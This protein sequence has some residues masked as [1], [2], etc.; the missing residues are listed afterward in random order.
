MTFGWLLVFCC[1]KKC[2]NEYPSLCILLFMFLPVCPWDGFLE[3]GSPGPSLNEK[4]C[5]CINQIFFL[6]RPTARSIFYI[7]T[8]DIHI[9]NITK[10]ALT[11]TLLSTIY[12]I[13]KIQL[14]MQ[15]DLLMDH[16][17]KF[18]RY[19]LDWGSAHFFQTGQIVFQACGLF[20]DW[21]LPLP[22]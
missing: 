3:E 12:F 18:K 16:D 21:T 20:V 14:T 6:P 22:L 4:Q 5:S 2:C 9:G 7:M 1:Y 13:F 19:W 8:Q 15:N 11:V 10:S 17:S